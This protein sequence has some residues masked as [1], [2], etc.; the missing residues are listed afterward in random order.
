MTERAPE[1]HV[2]DHHTADARHGMVHPPAASDGPAAWDERYAGVD[3]VWSGNP[4][5]ALVRAVEGLTPR[6][7]L[8]VG[9]GE[10]ADAVWLAARG[11][12]VTALDVSTVAVERGRRHAEDAGVEVTWL[13]AGLED[14]GDLSG[15]FD[16]V[17][18]Q[19]PALRVTPDAVAERI[20]A[21]A[22]APGGTL[23]VVHHADVDVDQARA[24]GF[25]P[26]DYVAPHDVASTLGEGWNVSLTELAPRVVSGGAGAHHQHDVVL[27]AVRR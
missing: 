7:V 23:L 21:D 22:V 3:R 13:V 12:Q 10:G 1:P 14:A 8:D 4:N 27:T 18:A 26:S 5:G 16:L 15:R 9:C 19:Y 20:L 6:R 25:D 17:S 24:N 11:W 2:H